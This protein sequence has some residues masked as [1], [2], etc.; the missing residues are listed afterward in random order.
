MYNVL[1][2][3]LCG[4]VLLSAGQPT[5][6]DV[7]GLRDDLQSFH[8]HGRAVEAGGGV[9]NDHV[10]HPS[11]G[12]V[13]ESSDVLGGEPAP[14]RDGQEIAD[15][16]PIYS[17]SEARGDLQARSGGGEEAHQRAHSRIDDRPLDTVDVLNGDRRAAGKLSLRQ[18]GQAS[19][20]AQ[21]ARS[22]HP[23]RCS[24]HL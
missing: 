10:H 6:V 7:V 13:I 8:L 2:Q 16:S 1:H 5:Q 12:Q 21:G 23:G 3:G 9:S 17:S 20:L 24:G 14:H 18:T 22:I 15:R 4:L 19:G 11:A